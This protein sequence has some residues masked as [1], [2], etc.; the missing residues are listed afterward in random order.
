MF[1]VQFKENSAKILSY[2][3]CTINFTK[4]C[5]YKELNISFFNVKIL[6]KST[7]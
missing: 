1:K 5:K 7:V 4:A 3:K 6:V 2:S